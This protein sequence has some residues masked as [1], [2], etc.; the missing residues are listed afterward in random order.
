LLI[1]VLLKREVPSGGRSYDVGAVV[2]NIATLVMLGRLLPLGQGLIERVVTITGEGVKQPGNYLVPFGTPLGFVLE[3]VGFVGDMS[4][5]I[6]GGPMMGSAVSS[7]DVPITKGTTA[8]V[9]LPVQTSTAGAPK[10]YP[11]IRCGRCIA[12]CPLR[13]NPS[14]LGLL[15]VKREYHV[16]QER[17][18]WR[19]F[20]SAAPA[21]MYP[22]HST[23]AI[24]AHAGL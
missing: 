3:Q 13:L 14:Q 21:L 11:C 6:L 2:Q 15:A 16:M 9:V 23:G 17:S 7:L 20:L 24:H 8:I 10:V 5:V 18:T 4:R 1:K 12:A 22:A 19:L